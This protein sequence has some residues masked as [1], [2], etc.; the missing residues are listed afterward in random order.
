MKLTHVVCKFDVNISLCSSIY[1][2]FKL[3]FYYSFIILGAIVLCTLE[4]LELCKG[5]KMNFMI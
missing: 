3:E 1:V 4:Y 2:F 5:C